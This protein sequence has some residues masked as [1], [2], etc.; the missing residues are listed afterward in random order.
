MLNR[1]FAFNISRTGC[2]HSSLI[3]FH[4]KNYAFT[5]KHICFGLRKLRFHPPKVGLSQ[6]ERRSF[7]SE[8]Y[9]FRKPEASLFAC[10]DAACRAKPLKTNAL[11]KSP[12]N[13]PFCPR[14]A[15]CP[16]HPFRAVTDVKIVLRRPPIL[17]FLP[18][19]PCTT[20][21][22]FCLRAFGSLEATRRYD[23]PIHASTSASS[24]SS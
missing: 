2:F 10:G 18:L 20:Y 23:S 8:T 15:V 7:A 12:H 4:P 3:A 1:K 16:P 11:Q 14:R 21:T 13:R 24:S 9:M 19:S 5:A 17:T 22:Y 6:P